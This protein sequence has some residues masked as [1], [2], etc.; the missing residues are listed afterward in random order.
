M[1]IFQLLRL[2]CQCDEMFYDCLKGVHS[3]TSKTVGVLYF[4]VLKRKCFAEAEN[5][6]GIHQWQQT[7][8]FT[9]NTFI[10]FVSR[11]LH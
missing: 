7:R 3:I 4:D 2:S 11:H 9:Q 8:P 6:S 5:T 1:Y 10:K